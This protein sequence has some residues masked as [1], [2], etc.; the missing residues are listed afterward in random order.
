M[1]IEDSTMSHLDFTP[2]VD[3]DNVPRLSKD[4]ARMS[5]ENYAPPLER[6]FSVWKPLIAAPFKGITAGGT[7]ET[8]L[9]EAKPNGAPVEAAAI[10][11]TRWLD[12]LDDDMRARSTFPVGS[13]EWHMWH[14]TPLLL[15][16]GQYQLNEL[17]GLQRVLAMEI[18]R[19]SLSDL[20][21]FR[22]N[23][24]MLNNLIL[25]QLNDLTDLM[26]DWSF[27][28]TIFGRP[29][30]SEPWG[31][32]LF[33]HHLSLNVMFVDG[34]M[35]LSPVFMGVEPDRP[36]GE[37]MRRLFEPHEERALAMFHSLSDGQQ[38]DAVL[39]SS[40]LT[41]DQPADRFHPDDGRHVGGA[42]THNRVVPYEG[43]CAATLDKAQ[44]L[45]LLNLAELFVDTMPDGPADAR[46]REIEKQI[47]RT[48]FMWIGTADDVNPFYFRIHSPVALLEFDHHSGIF[49]SNKEPERFHVHTC[50]RTPNGND[51]GFDLLRQHYAKGG[52]DDGGVHGHDHSHGHGAHSHD[53]GHTF[54]SHD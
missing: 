27:T 43:L 9:F 11:A 54:H 52:H 8:G 47:E 24:I 53:G 50:A 18:V 39:Y 19:A 35:V 3:P 12:S 10:A 29:S 42:Y 28:M 14:N 2:Y 40:M 41:A 23:E 6:L 30:T 22:T 17:P 31:W 37:H 25:G 36:V 38:N 51:Y 48:H 1:G 32:Q 44:R 34:Q 13:G 16:P 26:N 4:M 46:M 5:F 7:L 15:R 49:L 20:G 33:G 45:K 21:Y